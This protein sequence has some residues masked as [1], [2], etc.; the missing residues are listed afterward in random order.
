MVFIYLSYPY[1]FNVF[2]NPLAYTSTTFVV[3][4]ESNPHI[5]SNICSFVII[6]PFEFIRYS[7][8]SNCFPCSVISLSFIN[9]LLLFIFSFK[10]LN[11][12]SSCLYA[13]FV[14]LIIASS[15]A[16][17]SSLSNG[18]TRGSHLLHN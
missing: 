8:I 2:L 18:F 7:N 13:P 11:S 4:N 3:V 9:A 10:S 6:V 17:N 14:L 16:S 5:L 1:C 15:L 12:I